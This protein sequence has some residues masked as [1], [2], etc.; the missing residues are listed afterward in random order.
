MTDKIK[1]RLVVDEDAAIVAQLDAIAASEG[2]ARADVLR[3]AIR[4]L[5]FSLSTVPT[6]ENYSE[7]TE[8]V[9]A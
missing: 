8:P 9:T 3:R 2:I 5:L 4:R 1:I 7:P 6:F